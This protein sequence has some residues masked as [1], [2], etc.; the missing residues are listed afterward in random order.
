[1]KSFIFN[2]IMKNPSYLFSLMKSNI[3]KNDIEIVRYV[4]KKNS[5]LILCASN[6]IK[7]NYDIGLYCVTINPLLITKSLNTLLSKPQ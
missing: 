5:F 4:L 2:Q 3:I 6:E 7:N 1:M